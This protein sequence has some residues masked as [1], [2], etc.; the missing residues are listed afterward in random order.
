MTSRSHPPA[1]ANDLDHLREFFADQ[2]VTKVGAEVG[3][4]SSVGVKVLALIDDLADV[5]VHDSGFNEW[6]AAAPVAVAMSRG[7]AVSGIDGLPLEFNKEKPLV[8]DLVVC[9]PELHQV[10]L[11]LLA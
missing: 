8:A 1:I 2:G 4:R 6:D 10:V 3:A 9:R 7:F 11:D 5:Y